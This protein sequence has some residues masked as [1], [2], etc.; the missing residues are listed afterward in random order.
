MLPAESEKI[1][2]P[3]H[4]HPLSCEEV[5][6]FSCKLFCMI[7]G[8]GYRCVE[9]NFSLH[10][11]CVDR[12]LTHPF[13]CSHFLKILPT[14]SL[15]KNEND[16]HHDCHFC[17]KR[18]PFVLARCTICNINMDLTCLGHVP[19]RTIFQPKHH[20]HSLTLLPRLVTFTCNACGVE[21]D[22]NPYVCLSCNLMVH[23]DCI[24]LPRVIS[25]N[26]HDHR[27][28]HTFHLGQSQGQDRDWECGVC[29][30]KIN[31]VYGAF[32]CSRCPSYAVH[33]RCA[34]R[35]EVWDGDRA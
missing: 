24:D 26:R 25:I 11:D 29:R 18:L 21:S 32:K 6:H 30:K 14:A 2:L 19:P 3:F 12:C 8:V 33:S 28:S 17:K 27:I 15:D 20:T 5:D 10:K 35:S 23:K 13:H 4:D 9:C 31:W 34:I 7:T 1:T 22:R 16:H